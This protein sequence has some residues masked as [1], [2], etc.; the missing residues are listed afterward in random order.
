MG[1]HNGSVLVAPCVFNEDCVISHPLFRLGCTTK[2]LNYSLILVLKREDMQDLLKP[3]P[4]VAA[5]VRKYA[6]KTALRR[7]VILAAKCLN[8]KLSDK[9]TPP[10]ERSLSCTLDY[11]MLSAVING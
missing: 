7:A 9:F 8:G 10:I 11:M 6:V 4:E 2:T 1:I 5:Q 3:Y